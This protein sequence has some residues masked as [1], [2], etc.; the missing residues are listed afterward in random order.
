MSDFD[1]TAGF[2]N[3]ITEPSVSNDKKLADEV[4]DNDSLLI[5]QGKDDPDNIDSQACNQHT[6]SKPRRQKVEK[7]G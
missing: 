7:V 6:E 2:D 1:N 5:P 3:F 4:T